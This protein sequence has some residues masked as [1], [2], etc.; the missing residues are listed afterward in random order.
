MNLSCEIAQDLLPLFVDEVCSEQSR[1]VVSEHLRKCEK[2]RKLVADAHNIPE[3]DIQPEQ[4]TADKAVAKGL[5]KIHRRWR[6]SL[7]AAL[8]II[9]I[10]LL[11]IL[12]YNQMN[13]NGISYMNL[14]EII[15][16]GRFVNAL[17]SGKYENAADYLDFENSYDE[18]QEL[19]ARQPDSYA[20]QFVA[21][22]IGDEKWIADR[23]FAEKWLSNA[24]DSMQTWSYLA[25]N[26][27]HGALIPEH[28]W[29][30][31]RKTNPP[32]Y[33]KESDGTE[34]L[35]GNAYIRIETSWG[36]FMA[37][38]TTLE[39]LTENDLTEYVYF[40][41]VCMLPAEVYQD[42]K[43]EIEV[44]A[45]ETWQDIQ[46][47]YAHVA[48]MNCDEYTTNM[49]REY[50]NMLEELTLAGYSVE[51]KGFQSVYQIDDRWIVV[52]AITVRFGT[53][54]AVV[55]LDLECSNKSIDAV[56]FHYN[57]NMDW[58]DIFVSGLFM[59]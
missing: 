37:D 39:E 10:T 4:P 23:A 7:I 12:G 18:A 46:N 2:C 52:H 32:E 53:E 8:M 54:S 41:M 57:S 27:I 34:V 19:L 29:T 30:E 48:D 13:G 49:Q 45:S 31:I 51:K 16:A 15:T 5:K 28:A 21:V 47:R 56:G 43:Q 3:L 33:Q 38:K 6:L 55:Y 1:Q 59:N 36:T 25:Y 44:M 11:C 24:S 50:A 26:G 14:N 42:L 20:P 58:I 35:N 9:P 22:T 40:G 17:S